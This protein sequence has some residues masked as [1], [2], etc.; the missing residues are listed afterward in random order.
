MNSHSNND[1]IEYTITQ[2]E[3]INLLEDYYGI[4]CSYIFNHSN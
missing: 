3:S 4:Y 2:I 1:L